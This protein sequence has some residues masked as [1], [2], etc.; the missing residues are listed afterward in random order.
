MGMFFGVDEF[1]FAVAF[2]GSF[3][4]AD[5]TLVDFG[6]GVGLVGGLDFLYEFVWGH[7]LG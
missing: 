6:N 3:F 2:A 5:A 1:E 4:G 7:V